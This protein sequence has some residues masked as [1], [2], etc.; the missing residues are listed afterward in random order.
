LFRTEVRRFPLSLSLALVLAPAAALAAPPVTLPPDDRVLTDQ[1]SD[2]EEIERSDIDLEERLDAAFSTPEKV[3]AYV[4]ENLEHPW[5]WSGAEPNLVVVRNAG[6]GYRP[7]PGEAAYDDLFLVVTPTRV[8]QYSY[9][10]AEGT[11]LRARVI[12]HGYNRYVDP[13]IGKAMTPALAPGRYRFLVGKHRDQYKALRVTSWD[14]ERMGLP[15]QRR[16]GRRGPYD[17]GAVNVHKGGSS[18]NWSVGCF[19]IHYSKWAG[20]IDNFTMGKWG[21]MY[22][23]GDWDGSAPAR[24]PSTRWIADARTARRTELFRALEARAGIW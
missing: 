9:G 6:S 22:V 23:I 1:I 4:E 8:R 13:K 5:E 11:E 24:A 20:F 7:T 2:P 19:T 12:K 3:M 17:V 21:R 10:N 18:W 15:S 14:Y 16:N